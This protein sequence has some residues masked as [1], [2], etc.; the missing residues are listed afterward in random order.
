MKFYIG[1][2]G[3]SGRHFDNIDDF[4]KA[5]RDL[6]DTYKENGEDWFEIEVVND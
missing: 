3:S 1:E 2:C 4:F 6:A 5:L